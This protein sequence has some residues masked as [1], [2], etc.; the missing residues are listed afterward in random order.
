MLILGALATI[1]V[2]ARGLDAARGEL[3][4]LAALES[5]AAELESRGYRG[6]GAPRI[7]DCREPDGCR[8]DTRDAPGWQ[9]WQRRWSSSLPGAHA[10]IRLVVDG[11]ATVRFE[12]ILRWRKDGRPR[13]IG[14]RGVRT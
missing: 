5:L 2:A 8:L 14:L 9:A 6:L 4:A 3:L 10:T 1:S 12:L 11:T 7:A 13:A